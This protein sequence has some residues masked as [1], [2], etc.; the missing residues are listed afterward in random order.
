MDAV[1][2]AQ[3]GAAPP[4]S[5]FYIPPPG[6][7]DNGCFVHHT[8]TSTGPDEA[9]IVRG[10]QAFHQSEGVPGGPWKD[11]AY[12]WLVGQSGIVYEGRGWGVAG[13][14]TK[15]YNA[16]SHAVCFIGN[17]DTD[18]PTVEALAAI[19]SVIDEC[20]ARYG[21]P[22]RTHNAVN[23]TACP[24]SNLTAWVE[25][26]RHVDPPHTPDPEEDEMT[27]AQLER[28]I[29]A[30]KADTDRII[31]KLGGVGS[32]QVATNQWLERLHN[33]LDGQGQDVKMIRDD[34]RKLK[35]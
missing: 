17:S 16:S 14:H 3:W 15:G 1:S 25:S 22:V 18:V 21:G 20:L 33:S 6:M 13:G 5:P 9:A 10:V 11:I 31:E 34:V 28:L 8:V 32:Q 35:P 29:A 30:H 26:G 2:R 19:E 24:G 4:L 23:Q 7:F 12:S 27:D